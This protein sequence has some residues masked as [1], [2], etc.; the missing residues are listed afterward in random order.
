MTED[1]QLTL[2]EPSASE[3]D[4]SKSNK[5]AELCRAIVEATSIKLAGKNYIPIEGW[6]SIAAAWGCTP[7]TE[8][9]QRTED[10]Y[11]VKAV[12]KR[13]ADGMILS[14]AYGFVGDDEAIWAKRTRHANEGMAQTRAMSRVCANKFRFIPVLMKIENLATTPFEE[15]PGVDDHPSTSR[16]PEPPREAVVNGKSSILVGIVAQ[17]RP[18][19]FEG[20]KFYWAEIKG[21]SIFTAEQKLGESLFAVE[22]QEIEAMVRPAKK[23][24]R[25]ILVDFH[26]AA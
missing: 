2:V 22:G 5:V 21:R 9:P 25:W 20:K 16:H 23:P 12:L 15:M 4:W 1:T 6:Q 26:P 14:T 13:D 3:L 18:S 7:G 10:G 11:R 8:E 19:E 24:N 17:C